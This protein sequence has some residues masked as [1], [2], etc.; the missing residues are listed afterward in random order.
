MAEVRCPVDPRR[1]F[2]KLI[3]GALEVACPNCRSEERKRDP[4]VILVLHRY[5]A[6]SGEALDTLVLSPVSHGARR[7]GR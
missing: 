6:T 5:D 3:D 1:L 7:V 4:G 2:F